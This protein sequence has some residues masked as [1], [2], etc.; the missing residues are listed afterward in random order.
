MPDMV[1]RVLFILFAYFVLVVALLY[2]PLIIG[3]P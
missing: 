2:L 3:A 1:K